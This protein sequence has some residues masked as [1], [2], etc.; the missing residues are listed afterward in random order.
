MTW[1]CVTNPQGHANKPSYPL[2]IPPGESGKEVPD[3]KGAGCGV[4]GIVTING[5]PLADAQISLRVQGQEGD[6]AEFAQTDKRGKYHIANLPAGDALMQVQIGERTKLVKFQSTGHGVVRQDVAFEFPAKVS[7]M[8]TGLIHGGKNGINVLAGEVAVPEKLSA[9]EIMYYRRITVV[10]PDIQED[11]TY[12]ITG[13]EP[14]TYTIVAFSADLTETRT[15]VSV[16]N[17][18]GGDALNRDFSLK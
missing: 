3:I 13:L 1:G 17:V 12:Q 10:R 4:E 9:E 15:A 6:A 14:G 5:S 8:A 2:S 16:I 11:G 7:G 18:R